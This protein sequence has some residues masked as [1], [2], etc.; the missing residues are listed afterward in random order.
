MVHSASQGPVDRKGPV[1]REAGDHRQVSKHP[2]LWSSTGTVWLV[3]GAV[4]AAVCLVPLVSI[5]V[6]GRAASAVATATSV[7]IVALYAAMVAVRL[8]SSRVPSR[9]QRMALCFLGIAGVALVG[10]IICV[11]IQWNAV[12]QV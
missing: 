7:L 9:L 8:S 4:L 5:V 1:D 10:M 12:A 3:A 6:T 11:M 2:A